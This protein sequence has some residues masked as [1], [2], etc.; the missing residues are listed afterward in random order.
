M[1]KKES[2]IKEG[3]IYGKVLSRFDLWNATNPSI[4]LFIT[5]PNFKLFPQRPV[6]TGNLQNNH[7]VEC[8]KFQYK[9][10]SIKFF[11]NSPL[12][13]QKITCLF[14]ITIFG[15]RGLPLL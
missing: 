5:L 15:G 6:K 11:I 2:L 7:L 13:I 1:I 12:A 14:L 3:R 10:F 8:N 9:N 4:G